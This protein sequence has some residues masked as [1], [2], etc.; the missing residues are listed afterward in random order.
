MAGVFAAADRIYFY[1][2]SPCG[3]RLGAITYVVMTPDFYPR[4][5]CGERP[6]F[7]V[8]SITG[9]YISIHALLAESD[10]GPGLGGLKQRDFYP[11]SPCGER[12]HHTSSSRNGTNFY[13]RSPCGERPSTPDIC[14]GRIGTISIHALLAESDGPDRQRAGPCSDFYPRSPCGERQVTF[15]QDIDDREFL[16]TLSLRRAT[17][18]MQAAFKGPEISIHALLAESDLI[19]AARYPAIRIFLST[20]SLRRATRCNKIFMGWIFDFYPRSPCGERHVT[21]SANL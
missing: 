20:L 11:R 18:Q 21:R 15:W 13:P 16:S 9:K 2:R 4:S 19:F 12:R 1:P 5:P 3:E 6:T 8:Y 10:G 7:I 14:A 17:T